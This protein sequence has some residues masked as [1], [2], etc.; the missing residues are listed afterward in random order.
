MAPPQHDP[1]RPYKRAAISDQPRLRPP[2]PVRPAR[3]RPG[4]HP[5]LRQPPPVSPIPLFRR[6]A[7]TTLPRVPRRRSLRLHR[8]HGRSQAPGSRPAALVRPPDHAPGVDGRR[9][10]PPRPRL[11]IPLSR[12][13]I[14]SGCPCLFILIIPAI[15][16]YLGVETSAGDPPST[17]HRY[18]FSAVPMYESTLDGLQAAYS[19]ST[20][21]LK[22]GLLFYNKQAH[23][24]SGLTP[25]TLV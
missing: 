14:P 24:Q 1:R 13:R 16:Y 15:V 20:P 25:L 18:G 22:D 3:R 6:R 12:L 19:G 11:V 5:Q 23:Y 7:T 17:Y 10:S 8:R 9:S 21:Y 2:H 4:A